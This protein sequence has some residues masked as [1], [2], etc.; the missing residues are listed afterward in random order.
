MQDTHIH[1]SWVNS[2]DIQT[3]E[4]WTRLQLPSAASP[5]WLTMIRQGS[6]SERRKT[7]SERPD[8]SRCLCI[9]NRGCGSCKG[10][11]TSKPAGHRIPNPFTT[12][13]KGVCVCRVWAT[14]IVTKNYR[15]NLTG[16]EGVCGYKNVT[17]ARFVAVE[18]VCHRV[19]SP[20]PLSK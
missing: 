11:P 15:N 5:K 19:N 16:Y 17:I 7:E 9:T 4:G 13:Q 12:G 10:S 6:K 8:L 3:S 20:P 14:S 18:G 1:T 2:T